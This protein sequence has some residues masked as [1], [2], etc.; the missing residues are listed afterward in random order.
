MPK[1]DELQKM[2]NKTVKEYIEKLNLY[3]RNTDK[4]FLPEDE[5]EDLELE[6]RL[7]EHILAQEYLL[8]HGY[9]LNEKTMQWEKL[10]K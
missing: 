7:L 10:K 9:E 5:L 8:E 3:N 6:L 1:I 4:N 2:I